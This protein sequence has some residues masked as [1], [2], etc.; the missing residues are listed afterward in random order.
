MDVSDI[1][2]SVPS[3]V[4]RLKSRIWDWLNT[5]RA[6]GPARF[7][8]H[9]RSEATPFSSCF[10]VFVYDLFGELQQ[11]DPEEVIAWRQWLQ[12]FQDPAT[13]LFIDRDNSG[14]SPDP[15]HDSQH[16]NDQLTTFCISA[17]HALGGKLAHPLRFLEP[18]FEPDRVSSYLESL[19]WFLPWNCGN[20][21]MFL[22]IFLAYE[23]E[24]ARNGQA[25]P[26]LDAWFDWHDR[27]QNPDTGFWGKGWKVRYID[28]LGGAFHQFVVY[29]F[30]GRPI[31][32]ADR[33]VDRVLMMQQPDGMYSPWPGGAS[34]YELDAV[35]VLVHL[36][37]RHDYRR[38]EIRKAL[39]RLLTAVLANQ[40]RDGGF[41]WGH[42]PAT[43]WKEYVRASMEFF[44]HRSLLYWYL[45]CRGILVSQL[46]RHMVLRNGWAKEPRAVNESSLFD[47]WFR[48]LTI[49][50]I[51][52]VLT[53][54]PWAQYPWRFLTVPG[55]GWF[56]RPES[57]VE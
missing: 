13:G 45:S 50:E 51:S 10:A 36:Y 31:R 42:R 32:H 18:W 12:Q 39:R 57:I 54:L 27:H 20:K 53:D 47:T 29:N 5:M 9:R 38:D 3:E 56:R 52:H 11:L 33:I 16:L 15:M 44:S 25:H 8:L 6:S 22:G 55:L 4:K 30:V 1:V 35:D 23:A 43:Y 14:R 40:N 7:R 37:W 46:G 24:I 48:C 17:I 49:A 2:E 21:A 34:C 28:G 19:N 41:C 26:A